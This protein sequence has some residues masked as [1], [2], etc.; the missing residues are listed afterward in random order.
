MIPARCAH[1]HAPIWA[2]VHDGKREWC[3]EHSPTN[4]CRAREHG[5]HEPI[6]KHEPV[7][8]ETDGIPANCAACGL[9]IHTSGGKLVH[10][11]DPR[12]E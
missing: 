5:G 2:H 9:A 3:A 1:C 11:Y 10:G 4:V 8:S 6:T 12:L 7:D